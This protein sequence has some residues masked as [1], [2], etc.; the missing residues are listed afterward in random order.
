MR[1]S[2]LAGMPGFIRNMFFGSAYRPLQLV[3]IQDV[4]GDGIADLAQLAVRDDTGAVRIQV[5]RT[6][7]GVT[8]SNAY[9]GT[10]SKPVALVGIGNA[11]PITNTVPDVALLVEEPDGTAKVIA[12]NGDMLNSRETREILSGVCDVS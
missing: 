9:T 3:A 1:D 2:L 7:T 8:V 4:S 6:D 12:S 10:G 11:N 5:K